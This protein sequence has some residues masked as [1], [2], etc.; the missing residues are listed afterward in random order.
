MRRA[1]FTLI[2]L[3]M[4]ISIIAVLAALLIPLI[5]YAR[6]MA[7]NAKCEAQLGALK[8][9]LE[10]FKNA[11][12]YY[13]EKGFETVFLTTP[14]TTPAEKYFTVGNRSNPNDT[15]ARLSSSSWESAANLLWQALQ[16]V[17]RDNFHDLNTLRDPFTGGG[18]G[19]KVFRYRPAKFYPLRTAGPAI[20]Q[21]D[22]EDPP[23]P[24]SYQLWSAGADG[25]DQYS[26]RDPI[27]NRKGDDIANWKSP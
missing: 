10:L 13:P 9:A 8:S 26:E 1:G 7:R 25:K 15:G 4:V 23:N 11:N 18:S 3:L 21:I 5:G 12:G 2:E 20:W 19:G 14:A 17:D 22:S 27:T 16:S 6:T 24:D